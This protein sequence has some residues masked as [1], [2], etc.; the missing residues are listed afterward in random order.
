MEKPGIGLVILL[1]VFFPL[2]LAAE[3]VLPLSLQ[4]DAYLPGEAYEPAF[5]TSWFITN[6]SLICT[7]KYQNWTFGLQSDI[8]YLSYS[9]FDGT[10]SLDG[11]RFDVRVL[12]VAELE[13]LTWLNVRAGLGGL[14]LRSSLNYENTGWYGGNQ[15][16][17]SSAVYV[18]FKLP[19]SFLDLEWGN[20]L[21]LLFVDPN[22]ETFSGLDLFYK[23]GLK[24]TFYPGLLPWL[25]AFVCLDISFWQTTSAAIRPNLWILNANIGVDLK[26]DLSFVKKP[27]PEPTLKPIIIDTNTDAN[28]NRAAMDSNKMDTKDTHPAN[29]TD[30]TTANAANNSTAKEKSAQDYEK[31]NPALKLLY[32]ANQGSKINFSDIVFKEGQTELLPGSVIIIDTI[33][34]ILTQKPELTIS[35]SGYAEYYKDPVKEITLATG[36]AHYIRE[37]LITKGIEKNRIKVSPVTQITVKNSKTSVVISVLAAD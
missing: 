8:D 24:A 3:V 35:I 18:L 11:A 1:I 33:V 2:Q 14:W 23:S 21:D 28:T 30:N 12:F 27:A 7:T 5:Q 31:I 26:F 32:E 4:I 9:S 29:T 37:Y 22:L 34:E 19:W 16:G 20:K 25:A 13:W 15:G 10:S 17:L 6:L 36:R